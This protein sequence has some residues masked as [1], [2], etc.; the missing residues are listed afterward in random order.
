MDDPSAFS[1]A[2]ADVYAQLGTASAAFLLDVREP[3]AFD[4]DPVQIVGSVRRPPADAFLWRPDL[5][6]NR[7]PILYC[8]DGRGNSPKLTQWLIEA[9]IEALFL[10]GGIEEWRRLGLAMRRRTGIAPSQ[11]VTR[12]R[13]KVDRVACPWLVRRFIDPEAIFYYMRSEDVGRFAAW[14]GAVPYDMEGA[15]FGHVGE[16]CSFDAFLTKFDIKDAA[17]DRLAGIVR[18]A[19]TG[20]PELTPQSPG[21]LA[22]SHG[23]SATIGDD[24]TQLEHG[25][26]MYDAL[27][28]W[29]RAQ[30]GAPLAPPLR[31]RKA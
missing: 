14:S 11:W 15:E 20:K 24:Q 1:I 12:E 13:P 30:T 6:Q 10:E 25:M 31:T 18:G 28:A 16:R 19:D 21:L 27:Y 7:R 29:C 8:E 22:L 23:L 9:D 17:L 3:R 4:A 26:I 5:P 2:A